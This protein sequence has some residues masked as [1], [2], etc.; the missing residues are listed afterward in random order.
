[1]WNKYRNSNANKSNRFMII[2]ILAVLSLIV[3]AAAVVMDQVINVAELD[4]G[5]SD[6]RASTD[7]SRVPVV[8]PSKSNNSQS[9]E[10]SHQKD[11]SSGIHEE[12]TTGKLEED[13]R[14]I[15]NNEHGIY[16]IG[17]QNTASQ[18]KLTI[19]PQKMPAASIIKL[20]VMIETYN[21]IK[22]SRLNENDEIILLS[23]MKVGGTGSLAG[24]KDGTVITINQLIKLMITQSDN[25]ATNILIDRLSMD[26]INAT[27]KKLGCLDTILQRKMMDFKAQN[28]G[29]DNFTSVADL[30]SILMRI[31]QNDCLGDKYDEKMIEVMKLQ[32]NNTKIPR[33]LPAGT[34]VAHKTGELDGVENDTGIIFSNN[35]AYILCI[36]SNEVEAIKARTIISKVSKIVY[37]Y[38]ILNN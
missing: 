27:A 6:L 31:Y 4:T 8:E 19:N 26:R 5:K 16:S 25:T 35:G 9:E 37:D 24:K 15:I 29:K 32:E 3:L 7:S 36:L 14:T 23:S 2:A 21:A 1:M 30:C 10:N 22:E 28:E 13:I 18:N 38:N 17:Y 11:Q 12:L 20:F 33:L 34:V